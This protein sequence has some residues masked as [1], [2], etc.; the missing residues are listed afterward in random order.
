MNYND[1]VNSVENTQ[2]RP[3]IKIEND[4]IRVVENN[5]EN[6]EICKHDFISP[7]LASSNNGKGIPKRKCDSMGSYQNSPEELKCNDFGEAIIE[8][9]AI[10]FAHHEELGNRIIRN[11]IMIPNLFLSEIEY[12]ESDF[13]SLFNLIGKTGN[14]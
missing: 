4:E 13:L 14:A 5:S 8:I 6:D 12:I 2:W 9:R 1:V 7:F 3:I 10:G 11:N